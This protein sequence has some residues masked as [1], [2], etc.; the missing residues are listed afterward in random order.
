MET[1]ASASYP[2]MPDGL[3]VDV[4][5]VGG[6]IAGITTA[7]LLKQYGL[8]VAIIEADRI[9]NLVSGHT[10]AHIS[11]ASAA[12]YY[13][14]ILSKFGEERARM[15][16]RS[17]LDS[18]EKIDELVSKRGIDCEFARSTEFL[19]GANEQARGDLRDEGA[20]EA[21]LGLPVSFEDAAPLPF[22][23]HGAL[24]YRDQ[25]E[26]HPCKYLF[27]LAATVPGDG[28]HVFEQTRVRSIIEDGAC[29]VR[30]DRGSMIAGKVVIATGSPISNLGLL[31]ARMTV[32]RSYVLG[33]RAEERLPE[34]TMF[35]SSEEPCH[36]IRSVPSGLILVGGEDHLTG[37][38]SDTKQHYCRLER[39]C[40]V[41]FHVR[42]VEHS[43]SA[44]D[45]YPIDLL[46]F[47]GLL[48]GSEHQY[49]ATGFKG[50]GMTYG[51]L[52][53]MVLA[54]IIAKGHSSYEELYSPM[55]IGL[56]VSGKGLLKRNLHVA[57]M[58]AMDRFKVPDPQSSL[59]R[60]EGGLID[61]DGQRAAAYRDDNGS[62]HAASPVCKHM[63]CYVRWNNA[64]KSWD[65]PCHGSRYDIDGRVISS[66]TSME[67]ASRNGAEKR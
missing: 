28:S 13:R 37:E 10:T 62:L 31:P 8:N 44:Q 6:G 42:S 63:G 3:K 16:I 59:D 27:G 24:R 30:T 22:M 11:V 43:W 49:V 4:A 9:A 33:I 60:G 26:F 45:L 12:P 47:I 66:P 36:Y 20:V 48:P 34:H 15:C 56:R 38:V 65:C 64:E 32:R 46:P 39:Y 58:F 40:Q 2:V 35:Y 5:V 61:I 51:T 19:Y 23:T 29:T 57:E 18:I 7:V 53:G 1:A 14:K 52:S 50:T 17:V 41:N 25:A 54:D 21:G 67:L 55:R